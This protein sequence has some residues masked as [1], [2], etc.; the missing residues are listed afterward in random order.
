[1]KT[2]LLMR[3]AKSSWDDPGLKDHDRVLND[4]GQR[5]APEMAKWLIQQNLV[6]E[7]II[8]STALR[9]AETAEILLAQFENH[10]ELV[11]DKSLYH[12]S[13]ETIFSIARTFPISSDTVLL[14]AHNPGMG[15]LTAQLSGEWSNFP[16]AAVAIFDFDIED[17]SS[18]NQ[19][20]DYKFRTLMTPK[21][22]ANSDMS[23][24]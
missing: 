9:A 12:S 11:L 15:E 18:L 10:S 13:P 1:M 21:L 17:W 20:A 2:L 14:V 22:L 24:T 23:E 16:T 3:H 4:R 8:A 7:S 6:P 19:H 5:D